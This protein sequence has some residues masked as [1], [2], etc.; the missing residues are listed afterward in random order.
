VGVAVADD[1]AGYIRQLRKR[2]YASRL[3]GQNH[4][5]L[6][7]GDTLVASASGTGGNGRAFANFKA[8][9]RRFE[10]NKPTRKTRVR[11]T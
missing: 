7:F 10:E 2:G 9:V 5:Q 4:I 11:R 8:Q 3:D 1:T 6:W